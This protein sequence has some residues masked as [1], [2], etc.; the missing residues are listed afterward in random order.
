MMC[1]GVGLIDEHAG[2]VLWNFALASHPSFPCTTSSLRGFQATLLG[3]GTQDLRG[4]C[5]VKGD[6]PQHWCCCSSFAF[7][8]CRIRTNTA[9]TK[10]QT[11]WHAGVQSLA[12]RHG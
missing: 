4:G 8:V 5:G 9:V 10:R 1:G 7:F 2:L 12:V 3:Q 6:G 11:R